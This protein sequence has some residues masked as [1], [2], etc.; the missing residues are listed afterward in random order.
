MA[1]TATNNV[2]KANTVN[3]KASWPVRVFPNAEVNRA[4]VNA[5]ITIMFIYSAMKMKAKFPPPYSTLKPE[6]NSDSPSAKS[7]GV[8][9]VS[10]RIEVN[11]QAKRG[12]ASR[13]DQ[14]TRSK[15]GVVK[16]YLI[17]NSKE[18]YRR[19]AILISYEIVWAMARIVPIKAYFLFDVHPAASMMY[20]ISLEI[21]RNRIAPNGMIILACVCGYKSHITRARPSPIA[22]AAVKPVQLAQA[23]VTRCLRKSLI[24]SAK[25]CG[26]PI[27]PTL[28][29]PLRS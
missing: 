4:A 15:I 27:I 12:G 16:L 29:G 9:F 5:L 17:S 26:R 7:N 18:A 19:S 22:G 14:V 23:G 13:A 25:G 10:A 3:T 8:R 28:L 21:T 20:T 24:A 1:R 2:A 6:T 11:Q